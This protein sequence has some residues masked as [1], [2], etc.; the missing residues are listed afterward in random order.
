MLTCT[1]HALGR[2]RSGRGLIPAATSCVG[3]R[4]NDTD[5]GAGVWAQL[6]RSQAMRNYSRRT[7]DPLSVESRWLANT[8]D[9]FP[10]DA[11]LEPD[12]ASKAH[13]AFEQAW[14]ELEHSGVPLIFPREIIWLNGAPGSGKSHNSKVCTYGVAT[15]TSAG[16]GAAQRTNIQFCASQVHHEDAGIRTRADCDV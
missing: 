1:R 9:C 8:A 14:A 7:H 16:V 12:T 4:G 6:A 11:D 13:A 3:A 15:G 5:A 2:L 10:D